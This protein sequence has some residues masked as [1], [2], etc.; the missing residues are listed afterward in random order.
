NDG[1]KDLSKYLN[2]YLKESEEILVKGNKF[3]GYDEILQLYFDINSF[4][5]IM[6]LY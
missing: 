1:P 5:T 3:E 6:Q 2:L 4:N